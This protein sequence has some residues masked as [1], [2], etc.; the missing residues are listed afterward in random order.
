MMR[1]LER[2]L[3][4]RCP[5]EII[6]MTSQL[7]CSKR[8]ILVKKVEKDYITAYC[9]FRRDV[10]NFRIHDILAASPILFHSDRMISRLD[11]NQ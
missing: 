2:S 10:R 3:M 7:K 1:I 11:Q 8:R 9:Y 5:I 6:Y 4:D